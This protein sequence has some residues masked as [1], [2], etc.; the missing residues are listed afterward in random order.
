MSTVDLTR[1]DYKFRFEDAAFHRQCGFPVVARQEVERQGFY[2]RYERIGTTF[3]QSLRPELADL[4]EVA[5][6]LYCA[7]RFAPR[8]HPDRHSSSQPLTRSIHVCIGVRRPGVWR[9]RATELLQELLWQLCGD[10]WT[11]EFTSFYAKPNP[12]ETQTYLP[13]FPLSKP[14][15]VLLFSGG[16]DSF[17]GGAAQLEDD[18][19]THVLV[20]G[21]THPQMLAAQVRQANILLG[22]RPAHGHHVAVPYGVT[23]KPEIRLESSQRSR[24][25]LHM[26]LGA[27]TALHLGASAFSIYENGIG[28]L[29]LPFDETQSGWEVSRAMRLQTL[30]LME[31]LI[32]E[33]SGQS[34]QINLPFFF[35]TKAQSLGHSAVRKFSDG[36]QHTFSCDRFPD[37]FERKR[38]CGVCSSCLLRRMA[39]EA[40]DLASCEPPDEYAFDVREPSSVP[41]PSGAFVLDKFEAQADRFSQ[42]FRRDNP[43]RELTRLWP[44]LRESESVLIDSGMDQLEA[45]SRLL[46][47]LER[48]AQEWQHFSGRRALDRFLRAA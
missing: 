41:T 29:N 48:H 45:R 36:V 13:I 27:I 26:S 23:K 4:V 43:W 16:L 11:L 12:A 28:A 1:L 33:I 22:E 40:A 37:R 14:A 30:R 35:Q 25:I 3:C 19:H 44:E 21:Y 39:L 24:G 38:Q 9:G 17:A 5:T 47:L 42:A 34:F 10:V 6:A 20:S 8:R 7:D 32:G 2:N 46:A 15:M 18:T 31:R